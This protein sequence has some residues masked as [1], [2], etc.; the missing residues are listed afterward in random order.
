[1]NQPDSPVAA[2]VNAITRFRLKSGNSFAY[3]R[4]C[5][6]IE[7]KLAAERVM[8]FRNALPRVLGTTGDGGIGLSVDTRDD[9]ASK[10]EKIV[11]QLEQAK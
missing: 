11:E 6:L 8:S 3:Q 2:A 7:Q 5:V 9:I 4:C 10:V 1:M